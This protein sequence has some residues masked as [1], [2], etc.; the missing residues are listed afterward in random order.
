MLQE[1][2]ELQQLVILPDDIINLYYQ[3]CPIQA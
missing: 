2:E 3:S 1:K